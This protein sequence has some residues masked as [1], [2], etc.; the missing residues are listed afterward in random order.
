MLVRA[1]A[2]A[3]RSPRRSVERWRSIVPGQ[4]A[5]PP[6]AEAGPGRE[7]A[8]RRGLV[9]TAVRPGLESPHSRVM[10]VRRL[11]SRPV[12]LAPRTESSAAI[13]GRHPGSAASRRCARVER[14]MGPEPRDPMFERY[15]SLAQW[16]RKR[17]RRAS[18]LLT[19]F[20]VSS[21]VVTR[22]TVLSLMN[23]DA[24]RQRD[25]SVGSRLI[26]ASR[27]VAPCVM[28]GWLS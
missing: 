3:G 13:P 11:E 22:S 1:C 21:V 18:V 8:F 7:R 4:C 19:S 25:R 23:G 9:E 28:V 5:R 27:E 14:R 20:S 17:S 16:N 6:R 10:S 26:P 24:Q 15:H 12:H 2:S